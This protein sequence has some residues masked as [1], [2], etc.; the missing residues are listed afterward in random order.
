MS[1]LALDPPG[2]LYVHG[3][4]SGT[5]A[6]LES[7]KAQQDADRG[8]YKSQWQ[9]KHDHVFTHAVHF[10]KPAQYGVPVRPDWVS[11]KVREIAA[12]GGLPALRL[13]GLRH[14][15]ATA[16]LLTGEHLRLVADQLGHADTSV[17]DR[18]YMGTVRSAQDAAAGRVAA[19]ISGSRGASLEE[20]DRNG[21]ESQPTV[22]HPLAL[23]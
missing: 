21:T 17:T 12:E 4:D 13:H 9:D 3:I 16:A 6:A 8:C 5:V 22:V 1:R 19:L 10:S 15:W 20:R 14:S 23:G 7:W 11:R 2:R 18:V